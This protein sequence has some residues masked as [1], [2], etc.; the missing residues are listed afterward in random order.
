M[1]E[2]RRT[3]TFRD[4]LV[5]EVIMVAGITPEITKIPATTIE[6]LALEMKA[7]EIGI[8]SIEVTLTTTMLLPPPEILHREHPRIQIQTQ[9]RPVQL[10]HGDQSPLHE[11]VH[12]TLLL[13]YASA[14]VYHS[15]AATVSKVKFTSLPL[16]ITFVSQLDVF[17]HA[18]TR[19]LSPNHAVLPAHDPLRPPL[20]LS[21]PSSPYNSTAKRGQF[22]PY[23]NDPPS[24]GDWFCQREERKNTKGGGQQHDWGRCNFTSTLFKLAHT[25][26]FH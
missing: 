26:L 9:T 2:A 23:H 5:I 14:Y 24:G 3:G 17:T 16:S 10:V 25:H 6:V 20:H 19:R 8:V 22:L 15:V 7:T 13:V 1:K 11:L 18:L 21:A 4:R 12:I